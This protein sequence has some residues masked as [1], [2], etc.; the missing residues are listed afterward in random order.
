M[1]TG[2]KDLAVLVQKEFITAFSADGQVCMPP[3]NL[4]FLCGGRPGHTGFVLGVTFENLWE[5]RIRNSP[6]PSSVSLH[7]GLPDLGMHCG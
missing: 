7:G 2:G 6:R 5:R 4:I 3:W 1:T